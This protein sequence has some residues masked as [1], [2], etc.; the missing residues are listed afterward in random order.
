MPDITN[1]AYFGSTG[2]LEVEADN[3]TA[4]V[5]SCALVPNTP[6]AQVTDIGGGVQAFAGKPSWVL[7]V[8]YSQ[9]WKTAGSLS[10]KSIE[11]AGTTKTVKYTPEDGGSSLEVTVIFTAGQAGGAAQAHQTATISAPVVGQPTIAAAV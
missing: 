5:T 9:D 10:H 8:T 6:T 1:A 11:W 7:Q 3:Y 4:G 2:R